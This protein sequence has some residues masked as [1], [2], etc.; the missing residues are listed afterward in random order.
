MCVA[1]GIHRDTVEVDGFV[2]ESTFDGGPR[3]PTV[4]HDGLVMQDHPLVEYM[5]VGSDC[6]RAAARIMAGCPKFLFGF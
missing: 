3:L 1:M 5:G 4:Q 2:A 6:R